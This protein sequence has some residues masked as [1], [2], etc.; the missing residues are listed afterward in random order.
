MSPKIPH[1]RANPD[2]MHPAPAF[3]TGQ[4]DPRDCRRSAVFA[5]GIGLFLAFCPAGCRSNPSAGAPAASA[6]PSAVLST[7]P[8]DKLAAA[9]TLALANTREDQHVDRELSRLRH[10]AKTHPSNFELWIYLGRSWVRKARE[11]GD[12]GY[13]LN[14]NAAVDVALHVSPNDKLA[15]NLRALVLLNQHRFKE[16]RDLAESLIERDADDPPAW[17]SLSD[18]WLELGE[19]E[20][21]ENAAEKML[22]L[23]PDLS[24]FS[25]H[26]Y[27]AW[28]RG[29]DEQAL[30][31][32]RLAIDA[33]GD[34]RDVEPRAWLLV[35]T[36]MLFWHHG[37]YEGADAGFV[38]AL[39][40]LR[41]YPAALVG[42]GRV[43]M[44][45]GKKADAARFYDQAFKL[46]PMPETGAL[47]SEARELLGD[48]AGAEAAWLEVERQGRLNDPRALSLAYTSRDRNAEAA[49]RLAEEERETRGDLYTD[50]ALAW[51]LYRSRRYADAK[52][53]I[54]RALRYGTKDARLMFHQG[55]IRVA[56]GDKAGGKKLLA[57]ALKLNPHFD[58][59]GAAEARR[60]LEAP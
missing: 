34:K 51:A 31:S 46:S 18:A 19:V 15:L 2:S 26:G 60:L 55:A 44:A 11:S 39:E 29:N 40:V 10:V 4:R 49:L 42:R 56:T 13:Y 1:L 50:D 33:A 12:P 20:R 17:G 38:Q 59:A 28:I 24:S 5:L 3:R 41:N 8:A 45:Q 23:K 36:A 32:M 48:K 22:D 47:L 21:A 25:R 35:Q 43:A 30:E 14:A 57:A 52:V 58:V 37:D 54:D 27:L 6:S 9:R 53:A 16:A 7:A